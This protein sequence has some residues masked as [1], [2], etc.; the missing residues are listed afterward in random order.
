[1]SLIVKLYPVL[2]YLLPKTDN[3]TM[4]CFHVIYSCLIRWQCN[5]QKNKSFILSYVRISYSP[6]KVV[7]F[8]LGDKSNPFLKKNL[9]VHFLMFK[10]NIWKCIL[11]LND[12][13]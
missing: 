12:K 4:K 6:G 13:C 11:M 10:S 9:L 5:I 1:M 2:Y 3:K 8:T 7:D